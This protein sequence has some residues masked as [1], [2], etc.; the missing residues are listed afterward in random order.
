MRKDTE[1]AHAGRHPEDHQGAVNPPVYRTST[2]L[3]PTV[4]AMETAEKKP[5]DGMRYG[6]FGT[7]TTFAL[8]EAV[9][10]LEGGYRSISMPSGLAAI[11]GALMA[12]VEQ[13]DHLLVTDSV[14]HPT[15]RFCDT[16]LKKLGVETTYYD[17]LIGAGIQTL[18]RPN[19]KAVFVESPGSLTFEVQDIPAI[20]ACAHAR[21]AVVLMDNTWATPLYFQPFAKGVD[22]SIQA[23][24]KY[25]VGHADSMLGIITTTEAHYMRIKTSTAAF[26]VCPGSEEAYLGLRGLRTLG[27]RLRQQGESAI[28]IATWLKHRPEVLRVIHPALPGDLGHAL[29]VRDFTGSSG[30]FGVV[31]KPVSDAKVDAF[32]DALKLFGKG[33]SWGGYESLVIPAY[34][35]VARTATQW[36]PGG[37]LVRFHVGVEDPED[38]ICDLEQ[39][40]KALINA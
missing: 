11:T 27:L 14:Y 37:P 24:T 4:S 36:N 30:L 32:L 34:R 9:A 7:P 35:G 15:R 17:P 8:E 31:L 40:L 5:F 29:W 12:F 39:G 19:T 28:Q 1:I 2:V 3:Y 16:V 23:A 38:L 6:R 21:G 22:V 26:G 33:Y 13:G 20:A 18:M 10:K 25:I